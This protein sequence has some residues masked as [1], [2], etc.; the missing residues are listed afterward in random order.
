MYPLKWTLLFP[1][2]GVAV[3]KKQTERATELAQTL[4][5]PDQMR[6]PDD[7][8]AVLERGIQLAPQDAEGAHAAFAEGLS[9][10][11]GYGYL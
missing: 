11:Q 10:A 1:A 4:L 3:T 8:T 9:L 6:L 2:L 7:L 5:M